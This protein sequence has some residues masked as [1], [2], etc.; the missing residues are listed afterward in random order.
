MGN[1]RVA[2]AQLN[3]VVGDL[4]GN[5]ERIQEVLP[6]LDD[7][8]LAIFPE[9]TITG[10]PLEDLVLKPGFVSDSRAAVEKIA[11]D[12]KSCTLVIGFADEGPNGEVYNAVAI[13]HQG[14]I[15][16]IY[17]KRELPNYDVFD[18]ARHFSSGN[19][20]LQLYKIN[21]VNVGIVIC[22]D[23]WV[24]DGP[25]QEFV[26]MGAELLV[27]V[28]GSP[29][30]NTKAAA[31]EKLITN[32]AASSQIPVVYLNLVGGQD[33]LVFDGGSMIT[34]S[35]GKI[36]TQT[37]RFY[38][39]TCLVDIDTPSIPTTDFSTQLSH[40]WC[41][42]LS[43]ATDRINKYEHSL[44]TPL[45]SEAEL[46]TALVV[47]T[48]D[49]V[50]KSGFTDICLGL[51]GGVDSALVATIATDALGADHVHPVLMP[52][53]YSSDH[54]LN[55]AQDLL[56]RQGIVA[57]TIPIE[58][59]HQSFHNLLS[60]SI[61]DELPG[62]TD[63]NL[64]AR[65]RGVL[66][67]ALSNAFGWLVLTT[68]NKS[69]SAVGFSTLYGDTAGAYAVIRDVYKTKVYALCRWRNEQEDSPVI[70]ENILTK[71]PSAELR[72]DQRDDQRL[73]P[74]EILD[75][76]LEAY[77]EGDQTRAELIK[78]GFQQ[79]LVD[80]V[81]KMVDLAEYKRRQTPLG[82]RVTT[83]GFGRDR[84]LPVVNRYDG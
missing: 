5:V 12:S 36:V 7:C 50:Q 66:L 44:T 38:E 9:M 41:V 16:G 65:I 48:R 40:D 11:K 77:I 34:D 37:T 17:H 13:C 1:I 31:R 28:N 43:E 76:L 4:E 10:Y 33:E 56:E 54:S 58:E 63:E 2:L 64:Q 51:S 47:A 79:E 71:A 35:H 57:Q 8:D 21:G 24:S 45:S 68:G 23:L 18:E 14:Q 25:A 32:F 39:E 3:A 53:R 22:E 72:P 70:P 19:K 62:F 83:K 42:E 73:P 78:D 74:Y 27:A 55:D 61:G 20:P 84:R 49:Y 75:P 60:P 30:D 69:E 26:Q 6:N 29:Y 67:M 52:S 59:T 82:P 46:Y 80:Q 15:A 81:V